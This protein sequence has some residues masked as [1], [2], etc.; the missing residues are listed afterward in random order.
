MHSGYDGKITDAAIN[1]LPTL[2]DKRDIIQNAI[3]LTYAVGV[4][5]PRVAILSA[6]RKKTS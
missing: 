3:D 2:V 4:Q 6:V 1:V 5:E